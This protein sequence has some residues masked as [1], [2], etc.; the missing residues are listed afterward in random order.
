VRIAAPHQSAELGNNDKKSHVNREVV[1]KL[2]STAASVS[3][4][5]G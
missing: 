5:G 4:L 2:K 1:P 3:R